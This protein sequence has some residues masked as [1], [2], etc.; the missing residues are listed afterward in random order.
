MD[1][2]TPRISKIID[3]WIEEDIGN[4]DLTRAAITK[5]KWKGI[6]DRKRTRDI[7]WGFNN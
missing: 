5:K 1:C 7:L 2:N 4:G 6:L 3:D